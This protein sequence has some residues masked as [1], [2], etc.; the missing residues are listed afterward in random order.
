M[1]DVG[2]IREALEEHG[3][4]GEL[5]VIGDG[6]AA[7]RFVD[8]LEGMV[9]RPGLVIIDLN[10]PKRSGREV[11]KYMRRSERYNDIPVAILSSSDAARDRNDAL[12]L[13]A[14]RYMA[15]PLRLEEFLGLG[16]IFRAMLQG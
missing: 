13:G 2:L 14:T 10:L 6:D 9:P 16:V 12:Q 8:A 11:L 3:V 7:I 15:K 4:Q 5:L 1:A